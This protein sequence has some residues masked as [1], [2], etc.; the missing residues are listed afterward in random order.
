MGFFSRIIMALGLKG[1]V[2]TLV[3]DLIDNSVRE[4]KVEI[5]KS[6]SIK[7]TEKE[8]MKAGVDLVAAR[9]KDRVNKI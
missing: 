5:D 2:K 3:N 7:P 1:R 9:L 6:K 8:H 4:G